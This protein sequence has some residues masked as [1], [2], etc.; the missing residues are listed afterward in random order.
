MEPRLGDIVQLKKKH[1]CGS[2]EWEITRLGI[3]VGLR[4]LKC[5]RQIL[6]ERSIFERRKATPNRAMDKGAKP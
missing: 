6:I 3:R 1:P 4:C 5:Q 2:L